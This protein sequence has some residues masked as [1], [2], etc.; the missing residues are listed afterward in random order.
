MYCSFCSAE[1]TPGLK[2]CKRC[3]AN[4]SSNADAPSQKKFPLALTLAFL[5]L[6][7]FVLTIGM[8][9]PFAIASETMSRGINVD[10]LMP[11]LVLIPLIA[12]GAVGLLVWLLLRL[13]KVYQQSGSSTQLIEPRRDPSVDYTPARIAAPP[14]KIVSVTEHTTRNFDSI[15]DRLPPRESVK[16]T[17]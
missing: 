4:L 17:R 7:G 12:F 13:I 16:D 5:A 1:I 3:G 10:S 9:A 6:M 14:E 15:E 2:Y 11:I 8:I